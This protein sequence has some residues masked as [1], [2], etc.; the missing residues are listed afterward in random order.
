MKLERDIQEAKEA[1]SKVIKQ[2][3]EDHPILSKI[4]DY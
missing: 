2:T 3:G 1:I 4:T